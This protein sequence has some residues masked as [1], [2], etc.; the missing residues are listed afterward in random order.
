MTEAE[1]FDL[2]RPWVL[3]A[4]GLPECIRDHPGAPRPAGAYAM[5]NVISSRSAHPPLWEEFLATD[6]DPEDG[7]PFLSRPVTEWERTVSVNICGTDA[8][9]RME[10]LRAWTETAAGL[11]PLSPV[12]IA[13]VSDV[14]RLPELI[15]SVWEGRAQMDIDVRG[16]SGIG[17]GSDA[18]VDVA[19]TARVDFGS[20]CPDSTETLICSP[21]GTAE[22]TKP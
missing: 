3:A 5:L 6:A 19:E 21:L 18:P 1:L 22:A 8:F 17:I 16:V 9:D 14:R 4:T 7:A 15:G 12:T 2:L 13:R 20:C 10:R 11:M